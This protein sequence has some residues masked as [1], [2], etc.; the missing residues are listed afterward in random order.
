M[1]SV[2]ELQEAEIA[3]ADFSVLAADARSAPP[4]LLTMQ[5]TLWLSVA[6]L[7]PAVGL[8][9]AVLAGATESFDQQMQ[10]G[11][12]GFP[13]ALAVFVDQLTALGNVLTLV[14]V[15]GALALILHGILKER[16]LTFMIVC[17]VGGR[18]VHIA[19][20]KIVDRP[21]P[22]QA[23]VLFAVDSSSFPSGHTMMSV[24]V[25]VMF[26]LLFAEYI[27]K[28]SYRVGL[29]GA[30]GLLAACIGATRLY[31]GVHFVTDVVA[32]W[33]AGLAWVAA[34]WYVRLQYRERFAD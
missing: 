32:G 34:C 8:C 22:H 20:R 31:L 5:S 6:S 33:F 16:R 13:P 3:Q 14:C 23:D 9:A 27:P 17:L 21:R 28:R 1:M 19:L 2:T 24:V 4:R 12:F 26:A 25:Y 7:F 18:L 10:V 30:A 15:S 11:L 29:I